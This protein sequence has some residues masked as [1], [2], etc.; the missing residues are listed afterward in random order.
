MHRSI[1]IPCNNLAMKSTT[2]VKYL[3]TWQ[4]IKL[5][6]YSEM[7]KSLLKKANAGLKFFVQEKEVPYSTH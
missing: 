2:S 6:S 7:A 1:M 4:Y 3:G 5:C